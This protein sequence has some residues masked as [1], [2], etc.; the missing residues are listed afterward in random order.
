MPRIYTFGLD[1]P[2][3]SGARFL[4]ERDA[5]PDNGDLESAF[6]DGVHDL[7]RHPPDLGTAPVLHLLADAGC[8]VAV[9]IRNPA[10]VLD[11]G[12]PLRIAKAI[13]DLPDADAWSIVGAGG[14]GLNDS[15]H[16]ALYS[17]RSPAIP[18]PPGIR[19]LV[20]VMPDLYIVNAS[21]FES[22]FADEASLPDTALE[23]ILAIEGYLTGRAAL[24]SPRLSAGIVGDLKAR[25]I[26]L[27]TE[28]L[29][30]RYTECLA[31]QTI[32]TLS[33]D[34]S[35]AQ[36]A[37]RAPKPR[38]ALDGCVETVVGGSAPA[39]S[40]SVVVRTQFT[41]RHLLERLLSSLSRARIPEI[42]LEVVLSSDADL[43]T[44]ETET[45]RLAGLYINLTIRLQHN[46]AT[47][48]SR[49]D[50]LV[51]GAR[52]ALGDY[53]VFIDDDD[54]VDLFAFRTMRG[55]R[56]GRRQPL[57]VTST[58]IHSEEW[59]STPSGR[60]ILATSQPHAHHPAR[61]WRDMFSGVNRLP[62]CALVL[63]RERLVAR[64]D[65]HEI[66]HDL[67]ED[68]ALFLL[69]MTDPALPE[70]LEIPETLCHVSIRGEENSVTMP[71]RRPWASDIAAHLADLTANQAVA[72]PGAWQLL[73]QASRDEASQNAANRELQHTIS[74]LQA[75]LTIAQREIQ[76]LRSNAAPA[77][78]AVA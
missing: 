63:P 39:F 76:R 32:H 29:T 2:G 6:L 1:R 58:E 64:L 9:V 55:A 38:P 66:A 75:N 5:L 17:S 41:R 14:L 11:A 18:S 24:F 3:L 36:S 23:T 34:V 57:I 42:D 27:L 72:G 20:D 54:Y 48:H 44:A 67:S 62:I 40:V 33:G 65:Q 31:G 25:D 22:A 71:D 15:R 21:F 68:Y 69:I 50:N 46:P 49:V 60:W 77:L 4:V 70:I 51:G 26:V 61:G 47:G 43:P 16:L 52:A 30:S 35:I 8:Q 45:S 56:F 13:A 37:V 12:L 74:R 73:A 10:L 19:P 59:Q 78:E 53:V 28:E 7:E